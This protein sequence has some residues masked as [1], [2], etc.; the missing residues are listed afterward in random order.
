MPVITPGE[1]DLGGAHPLLDGVS[2]TIGWQF[3][4]QAK[5]GPSFVV[6]RRTGLGS[7]KVM[8][9]FPLT[10]DGWA[11]AWQSLVTHNPAAAP[12]ILA[13][14]KARQADTAR[15]RGPVLDAS[16]LHEL[17]ARSMAS[18]RDLVYLGGYVS[19]STITAGERCDVRFA[20]DR[21][22]V[23]ASYRAD[24][25]AVVPYSQVEDLEIGGPGLVRSG[26]GFAGGGFGPVGAIEGMA[27]AAVLNAM[28]TRT[29]IKTIVRIQATGSELFLLHT[30]IT[31]EQ[32]RIQMSRTLG[33]IR[34]ARADET[35]RPS[36]EA[37][38]VSPSPVEEL[39]KLA[40]MLEKGLLT[41]EEFDLM[42]AKILGLPTIRSAGVGTSSRTI[43]YG[44][45]AGP[46]TPQERW[47]T[48]CQ[49]EASWAFSSREELPGLL[50]STYSGHH[51]PFSC[52]QII[53][54]KTG[55]HPEMD[56]RVTVSCWIQARHC[57]H[58]SGI[59]VTCHKE[60]A[61]LD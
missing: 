11:Y 25:L 44:P 51:G 32:L 6:L 43:H 3:Q 10:E 24:I 52:S 13:V 45:C 8:E 50:C 27:V 35:A 49:T 57:A 33:V 26:G 60:R 4:P 1:Q 40:D 19:E 14:L 47:S 9:S 46:Y 34:A 42:K 54:N 39:T 59:F 20:E 16:E 38:T 2:P 53:L 58:G 36:P 31:P 12:Q 28:T 48:P 29:S 22:A 41:R 5:G 18:L 30:K 55:Q 15:L 56:N 7:L 23:F 61:D 17:D 21:L 37:R